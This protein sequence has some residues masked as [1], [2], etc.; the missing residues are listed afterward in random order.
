MKKVGR[1]RKKEIKISVRDMIE[2]VLRSGDIDGS[3]I[4][5]RRAVAGIRAHQLVQKRRDDEQ[6]QTEVSFSHAV[7]REK[8]ILII[9]GRADGIIKRKKGDI[10]EEIKSTTKDLSD[11]EEDYDQ[12][13]WGQVIF[14][15]Y[16]HARENSLKE[17][18][19]RLTYFRLET[20]K[21][22][23]FERIYSYKELKKFFTDVLNKYLYWSDLSY[24]LKEERNIT[25]DSLD[26]PYPSYR[27]GQR[28]MAV[29]VYKTIMDNKKLYCQAPTGIGKTISALYPSIKAV[30]EGKGEKIFYLTAKTIT[31]QIAEENISSLYD[32]GLELKTVTLTARDKICFQPESEC[33][34]FSCP[35]ARGHYNRVNDGIKE[36]VEKENLISRNVIEDYA[37]QHKICPFEFSLDLTLW[38]DLII[39]DYNYVFDP[40]VGLKRFFSDQGGD[41]IFLVDEAHNLV[42]RAR[43]MY[44][45]QLLKSDFTGLKKAIMDHSKNKMLKYIEKILLLIEKEEQNFNQQGELVKEEEPLEYYT[46]LQGFINRAEEWLIKHNG[47]TSEEEGRLYD[48]ILEQYFNA[49]SFLRVME[50][51]DGNFVT[52]Y[53]QQNR[54]GQKEQSKDSRYLKIRIF[55]LDPSAHLNNILK[56]GR[57]AVFFSATLAPLFYHRQVLGGI[58]DDY[59]LELDSPFDNENVCLLV[60]PRISTKYKKRKESHGL[61]VKYIKSVIK[62]KPGNYFVFFPSYTYMENVFTVFTEKYPEINTIRQQPGL[63]E[64]ERLKFLDKFSSERPEL[65]GFAV[66]G[67]VFSEGIDLKGD[68][69]L[70]TIV[71]G[72]G[73][74]LLCLERDLIRRFYQKKNGSGY[75]FAY[76]YPGWNRVL[77]AAG[78]TIRTENDRGVIFLLGERFTAY[79]YRKLLPQ[80]WN[81][82]KRIVTGSKEISRELTKFWN[83]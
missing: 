26:F 22:K 37:R 44:S 19:V 7:E 20:E 60:A 55:C 36:V 5:S 9:G 49:L 33:T 43:D 69:L 38:A 31:R 6:Y 68:R 15:A 27:K 61:I 66:L 17:M 46:P 42:D 39:C 64:N 34:P 11:I 13:H 28:K 57:A 16:F 3:F 71:I 51:Y 32:K 83:K 74:P 45:A 1:K 78:R 8:Y 76:L 41:Y 82:I 24:K 67:G 56:K 50:L 21:E 23:H 14:Y 62:A 79:R 2:F 81:K 72:I 77:Q 29:A 48:K 54:R 80:H 30:G 25:I 12:L 40:R 52:Y 70:G 35:Y 75:E 18:Q 4:A 58:E 10:I 73:H 59:L 47:M 63:S 65:V 53:Q